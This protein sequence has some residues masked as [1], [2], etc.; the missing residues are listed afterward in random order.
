MTRRQPCISSL[1][2]R[3]EKSMTAHISEA[4]KYEELKNAAEDSGRLKAAR[5]WQRIH[6]EKL[7]DAKIAAERED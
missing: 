1:F 4:L 2:R 3:R 5:F 6:L 7:R